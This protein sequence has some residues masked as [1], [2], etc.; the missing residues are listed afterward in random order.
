MFC[1]ACAM[2]DSR[3]AGGKAGPGYACMQGLVT[4]ACRAWLRVHAGPGHGAWSRVHAGP[5]HECMQGLVTGPCRAWLRVHA[6]P[7][8]GCMQGLVTSACRAWSR[9]HAGARASPLEPMLAGLLTLLALRVRACLVPGVVDAAGVGCAAQPAS[10]MSG[11][12]RESFALMLADV[13][14]QEHARQQGIRAD[15]VRRDIRGGNGGSNSV[16]GRRPVDTAAVGTVDGAA[17]GTLPAAWRL[18]QLVWGLSRAGHCQHVLLDAVALLLEPNELSRLPPGDALILMEACGAAGDPGG[19][20]GSSGGGGG[21]SQLLDGLSPAVAM[22][23]DEF[24]VAQLTAAVLHCAAAGHRHVPLLR[25]ACER[26]LR[27]SPATSACVGGRALVGWRALADVTC[28]CLRLHVHPKEVL[29][30]A[31]AAAAALHGGCIRGATAAAAVTDGVMPGAA[32][33]ADAEAVAAPPPPLLARLAFASAQAGRRDAA[34]LAAAAR[35]ATRGAAAD[36]WGD[37]CQLG[38]RQLC[39]LAWALAVAEHQAWLHAPSDGRVGSGGG[40]S[41]SVGRGSATGYCP[42]SDGPGGTSSG[43]SGEDGEDSSPANAALD[44]YSRASAAVSD[45]RAPHML[46]LAAA[47]MA[48]SVSLDVGAAAVLASMPR[49]WLNTL[50]YAWDVEACRVHA[51]RRAPLVTGTS[52]GSAG[53]RVAPDALAAHIDNMG[54]ATPAQLLAAHRRLAAVLA[55][56]GVPGGR[57]ERFVKVGS[58]SLDV[59]V[60]FDSLDGVAVALLLDGPQEYLLSLH[61]ATAQPSPVGT[62]SPECGR[63]EVPMLSGHALWR[64]ALLQSLGWLVVRV[65]WHEWASAGKHGL[66]GQ[67]Q[68]LCDVLSWHRLPR[69]RATAAKK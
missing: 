36:T 52:G 64:E 66:A 47:H 10:V 3:A 55:D 18:P 56:A 49:A 41:V 21:A 44:V 33:A 46:L 20:G 58:F 7:G 29:D 1:V 32:Q 67:T 15:D 34:L 27:A 31:E 23:A 65:H 53:G 19:A 45:A 39:E 42:F 8:H 61:G 13:E 9:V 17:S 48:L 16:G 30:A 63:A 37:A 35:A 68:L 69:D 4:G 5:G 24:D 38:E 43:G 11:V 60:S 22:R 50:Q 2:T 14:R 59:D 6:G 40:A 62:G 57:T 51:E 26:V 54:N 25:A 28:A 12:A